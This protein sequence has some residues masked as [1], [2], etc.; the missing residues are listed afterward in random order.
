MRARRSRS[1]GRPCQPPPTPCSRAAGHACHPAARLAARPPA[2]QLAKQLDM[3]PQSRED[4]VERLE[5]LFAQVCGVQVVCRVR[6]ECEA[7]GLGV[8]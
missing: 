3:L 4:A 8:A 1:L 6:R 2:A 5:R 7:E